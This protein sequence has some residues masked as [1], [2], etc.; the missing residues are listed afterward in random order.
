[1]DLATLW[2]AEETVEVV[3]VTLAMVKT[4]VKEE[5]MVVKVVWRR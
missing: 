2:V 3:E 4:L 5:A 1:M